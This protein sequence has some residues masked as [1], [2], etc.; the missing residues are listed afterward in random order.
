MKKIREKFQKQQ[1]L[2][3]LKEKYVKKS[4][5]KEKNGNKLKSKVKN[6]EEIYLTFYPFVDKIIV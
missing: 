4:I 3:N 6:A 5:V 1:I 2:R